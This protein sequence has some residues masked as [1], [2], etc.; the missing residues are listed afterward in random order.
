MFMRILQVYIALQESGLQVHTLTGSGTFFIILIFVVFVRFITCGKSQLSWTRS[1]RIILTQ[2]LHKAVKISE[3]V[4]NKTSSKFVEE[5]SRACYRL[6]HY[7]DSLYRSYKERLNSSEWQ[8]ALRLRK[9][10]FD[11]ISFTFCR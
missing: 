4:S 7:S 9:G 1:A 5:K 11:Y 8:N 2:Y 10:I 3:R 6:A